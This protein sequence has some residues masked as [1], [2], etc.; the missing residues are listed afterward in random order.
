MLNY[1]WKRNSEVMS[2]KLIDET[3]A[4]SIQ[5]LRFVLYLTKDKRC[6]TGRTVSDTYCDVSFTVLSNSNIK[7]YK[8]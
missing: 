1:K 2:I 3:E 6:I 4:L 8:N 7:T 5:P